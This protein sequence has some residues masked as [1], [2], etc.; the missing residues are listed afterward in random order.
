LLVNIAQAVHIQRE[1]LKGSPSVKVRC[2][3]HISAGCR[4]RGVRRR[5]DTP[6]L[7]CTWN[8]RFARAVSST[9]MMV[10]H[11]D[12]PRVR[13]VLRTLRS[14]TWWAAAS[15]RRCRRRRG[16][17]C[18]ACAWARWSAGYDTNGGG[19]L[20]GQPRRRGPTGR[21]GSVRPV[22]T[23]HW[24]G[25]RR[26]SGSRGVRQV[27]WRR[28][29]SGVRCQGPPRSMPSRPFWGIG[30]GSLDVGCSYPRV[31]WGVLLH[32]CER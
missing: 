30:V 31:A 32:W 29:G 7:Y 9:P 4:G 17:R 19:S 16:R 12:R 28:R 24:C 8:R 14:D 22:G 3:L 26:C 11:R 5:R 20:A 2:Y 1:E 21:P 18:A 23:G 13:V 10:H 6:N 15:S 27:W 25:R